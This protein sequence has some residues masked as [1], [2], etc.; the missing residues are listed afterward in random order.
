M[1]T[2]PG[3]LKTTDFGE[4]LFVRSTGV[5]TLVV[6]KGLQASLH[7]IAG[8]QFYSETVEGLQSAIELQN[9]VDLATV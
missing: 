6:E 3:H 1:I 5:T 2:A 4:I 7:N 9:I 8:E